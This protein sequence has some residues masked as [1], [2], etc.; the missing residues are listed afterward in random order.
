MDHSSLKKKTISRIAI[1]RALYLGDML[2]IVPAVRA[3]RKAYPEATITLIGLPW[4]KD[5]VRR[6]SHYFDDFIQFPGWPGLPE[7]EPDTDA[8]FEFLRMMRQQNF[9][10]IFQMQGNGMITNTM[11][12]L[13]GGKKVY[14][15]Q[16]GDSHSL[17]TD[18]FPVSDDG[19][20]E[21]KKF[22]KLLDVA[23]IPHDGTGLEFPFHEEEVSSIQSISNE[24]GITPR[25]YICLH[26]GARD[27]RRRWPLENFAYIGN[28]LSDKGYKLV[29][30]GSLE[31]GALLNSLKRKIKAPVINL[32]ET[33][34]HLNIGELAGI[35]QQATLL[36]SNDT[37]VSHI[38][39][40]LK[41]PSFIIFSPYADIHRWAPLDA[42]KHQAVPVEQANDPEYVLYRILGYLA[43]QPA[44]KNLSL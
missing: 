24:S 43:K 33:F 22:L 8:I 12:M 34:G 11:C 37:G 3:I 29:L 30:T 15:L 42:T 16:R 17:N 40:A 26:P 23:G 31:E 39:A 6:F 19:E 20:N 14:G 36:I 13:W 7:Q 2:C 38:A 35:I 18:T 41:V 21:I 32:V 5:F 27:K 44:T 4:Q 10:I 28:H 25:H 1:F 9:H